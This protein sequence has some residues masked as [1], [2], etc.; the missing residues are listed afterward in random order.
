MKCNQEKKNRCYLHQT[1]SFILLG[2]LLCTVFYKT[3][4]SADAGSE[5]SFANDH[6]KR[7]PEKKKSD[8]I[9]IKQYLLFGWVYFYVPYF[10]TLLC[11][12]MLVV[13]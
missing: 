4:V 2:V 6:I 10:T 11:R 3:S 12:Q 7:N 13:N 1:V 8:V 5:L 9:S